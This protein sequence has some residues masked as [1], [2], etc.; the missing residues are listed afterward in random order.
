MSSN[1][2]KVATTFSEKQQ[3]TREANAFRVHLPDHPIVS[4]RAGK[5]WIPIDLRSL[6]AYRELLYFLTLRDIKVKYRQTVLGVAWA[7][8]Q[9]LLSMII[10]TI[11][12]GKFAGMPSDGIPYPLF[13][14]AGL[15][16]WTFF[17][18]AV[19]TS[20]NSLVGS[21]HLIT[22][23]Y[24]P[25]MIIPCAAVAGGLVDLAIATLILL[26]LMLVYGTRI[27]P[28]LL[29]LPLLMLM[30]T[31]LAVGVGMWLSAL[32]VKYRD[33][34]YALPF[35]INML[36]FSTP[37]IYPLS[38]VPSRWQWLAR[39]NPLTGM[40]EAIRAAFFGRPIDWA[41]LGISGL[42]TIGILIVA[43]FSFRKMERSFADIV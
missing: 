10:F 36:M 9:P 3:P 29:L 25:R 24:F 32:N 27:G 7:I 16:P 6:W 5:R 34:R 12:F 13:T 22:K 23:V 21:A 1:A 33:I 8:L 31:A 28:S 2:T 17:S 40:I 39:L 20:G 14:Y 11:F 37:I 18:N 26:V 41:L 19:T 35:A 38:I 30:I 4:I 43:A 42:L 15:L